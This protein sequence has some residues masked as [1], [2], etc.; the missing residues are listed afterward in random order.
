MDRTPGS[1]T[2]GTVGAADEHH[3]QEA[4]ALGRELAVHVSDDEIVTGGGILPH[5]YC[6][7]HS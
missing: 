3:V 4:V 7:L 2:R 5:P 6:E 1:G